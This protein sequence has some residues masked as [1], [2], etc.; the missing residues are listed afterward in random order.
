MLLMKIAGIGA[1]EESFFD[2]DLF[3]QV[4]VLKVSTLLKRLHHGFF[5]W[6]TSEWMPQRLLAILAR[7]SGE[8][9]CLRE[10]RTSLKEL[11]N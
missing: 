3:P 11:Y 1:L 8:P 10:G 6:S 5:D 7:E 9:P 2:R 4:A